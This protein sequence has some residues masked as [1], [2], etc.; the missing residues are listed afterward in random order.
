MGF[1]AEF[2]HCRCASE[3][4]EKA[5]TNKY[6]RWCRKYGYNFSEAKAHTIYVE[7][8]GYIGVMPK[9]ETAKLLVEQVSAQLRV[10]S[11]ALAALK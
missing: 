3:K 6:Q 7:T 2:W 1:V 11:A 4:S 9:S 8:R 5:F 10:T